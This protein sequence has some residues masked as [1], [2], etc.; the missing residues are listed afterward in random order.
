M[1][2]GEPV[3]ATNRLSQPH[4]SDV[5][6]NYTSLFWFMLVGPVAI[7]SIPFLSDGSQQFQLLH[8]VSPAKLR[9][10]WSRM[11]KI[12]KAAIAGHGQGRAQFGAVRRS[13]LVIQSPIDVV[14]DSYQWLMMV[15]IWLIYG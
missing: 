13:S 12:C 3:G 4:D 14:N 7:L 9:K 10:V 1:N 2:N 11:V 15:N 6:R 5:I 8:P